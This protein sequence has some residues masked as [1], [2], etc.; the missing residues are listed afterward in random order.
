MESLV[1]LRKWDKIYGDG[2]QER[3]RKAYSI[4][5]T[6]AESGT[7][8]TVPAPEQQNSGSKS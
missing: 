1:E 7:E 6:G 5:F 2:A 4:G 3:K 8:P